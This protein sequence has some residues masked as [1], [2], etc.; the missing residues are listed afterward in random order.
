MLKVSNPKALCM[1]LSVTLTVF[2]ISWHCGF[3]SWFPSVSFR[4]TDVWWAI[5][6]TMI[7]FL[8]IKV[9]TWTH[10]IVVLP[11]HSELKHPNIF[12]THKAP[13]IHWLIVNKHVLKLLITYLYF[14]SLK[15]VLAA[16]KQ[17]YEWFSPSVCMSAFHTYF[18]MLPSSD[19]HG[20]LRRYY[21]RQEWCPDQDT[22]V[23]FQNVNG[24]EFFLK[25]STLL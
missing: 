6:W 15:V 16:T 11:V 1:V 8:P 10:D 3:F 24:F 21:Q 5:Y 20:M 22:Q 23:I 25:P 13:L 14:C 7:I 18:T 4:E 12:I 2:L 17:L 9:Y 19:H